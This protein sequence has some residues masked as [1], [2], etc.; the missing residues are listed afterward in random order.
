MAAPT[1]FPHAS[2]LHQLELFLA[3]GI[4]PTSWSSALS[5]MLL[6]QS[7]PSS[8]ARQL[9]PLLLARKAVLQAAF[10]TAR[11]ADELRRY[12]KF[13]KPD[14]PSPHIVQLRQQQAAARQASSQ[15]RQALIKAAAAFVREAGIETPA[16]L[17]LDAFINRWMELQ[18][19]KDLAA[20]SGS[21]DG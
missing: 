1:P 6:T 17:G 19:P 18:L 4:Q 5:G 8:A 9:L 14:R 15:S 13:V 20:S 2:F 11:V 16:R 21:V 7:Q 3:D 12:Q 10:H